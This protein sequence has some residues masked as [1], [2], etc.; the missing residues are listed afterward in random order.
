MHHLHWACAGLL[1]VI[2]TTGVQA[3]GTAKFPGAQ[4]SELQYKKI[5]TS[6]AITGKPLSGS[7]VP[8][9]TGPS[10]GT[11]ISR[12]F[13]RLWFQSQTADG[14]AHLIGIPVVQF[15][16]AAAADHRFFFSTQPK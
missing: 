2:L 3:Q 7:A 12:F 14:P 5:D 9:T 16:Q 11:G 15:G 6:N 10:N 4:P 1:A 13:G 8:I